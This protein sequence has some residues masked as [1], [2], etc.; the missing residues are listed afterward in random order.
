LPPFPAAAL[1]APSPLVLDGTCDGVQWQPQVGFD[2]VPQFRG[3]GSLLGSGPLLCQGLSTPLLGPCPSPPASAGANLGLAVA[4]LTT[5]AF[6]LP[7][8]LLRPLRPLPP[9]PPTV[10]PSASSL[11]EAWFPSEVVSQTSTKATWLQ[12]PD[13]A[14][15][16]SRGAVAAL[17]PLPPPPGVQVGICL[18]APEGSATHADVTLESRLADAEARAEGLQRECLDLLSRQ[19]ELLEQLVESDAR[20]EARLRERDALAKGLR[21]ALFE[22]S[23]NRVAATRAVASASDL[24]AHR[25]DVKAETAEEQVEELQAHEQCVSAELAASHDVN[26]ELREEVAE[27]S[28]AFGR[29]AQQLNTC[30]A[31]LEDREDLAARFHVAERNLSCEEAELS[32]ARLDEADQLVLAEQRCKLAEEEKFRSFEEQLSAAQRE[33]GCRLLAVERCCERAEEERR[34]L[35]EELQEAASCRKAEVAC[36]ARRDRAL[37]EKTCSDLE[38]QL[39]AALA[40]TPVCEAAEAARHYELGGTTARPLRL[41]RPTRPL[42]VS[43]LEAA[44][45]KNV[46]RELHAFQQGFVLDKVHERS[47]KRE[48]RL[49]AVC[50]EEMVLR[51]SKDLRSI[52]RNHSRLDLYEV[53]LIHYGTMARASTLYP[54]L[55]PWLCFS[56]YTTRRSY[57]FCCADEET[58]QACVLGLSCL[59]DW[60]A[61]VVPNS[62]GRF[63]ALR[64]WCKLQ[65][66]LHVPTSDRACRVVVQIIAFITST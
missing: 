22:L 66:R 18:E 52:G 43:R 13:A 40:R 58:V 32:R 50:P 65:A 20:A 31:S 7:Q 25:A 48:R 41:R 30:I 8:T 12:E 10:M 57:D 54:E 44:L 62:R 9:P 64:G 39:A 34:Q 2:T 35:A 14:A 28:E 27:Q 45:A 15:A 11:A 51:W 38:E 4:S 17:A 47:C 19:D 26:A 42:G 21:E 63:A 37:W 3:V 33:E 23:E 6:E 61:G 49:V 55:S 46:A 36:A 1:G 24:R 60:A 29:Q 53:I 56:L 59:C 16:T 5:P